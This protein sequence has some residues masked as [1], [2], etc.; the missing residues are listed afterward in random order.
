MTIVTNILILVFLLVEVYFLVR[1]EKRLWNS[2]YTPVTILAV[3]YVLVV[4]LT[5]LLPESLGFV[6]LYYPSLLFWIVGLVLLEVPSILM[7]AFYRKTGGNLDMQVSTPHRQWLLTIVALLLVAVFMVRLRGMVSAQQVMFGSDEFGDEFAKYGLFGHLLVFLIGCMIVFF[8]FIKRKHWLIPVATILSIALL[9]FVNQVKSWVIIPLLAGLLLCMMMGKVRMNMRLLATISIVGIGIF[10]ASY[11]VMFI[12]VNQTDYSSDMG[13]FIGVHVIHYLTSGVLGLS[14]DM[15][16][17]IVET[18]DPEIII[19]PF[20]NI[21]H[22][23]TGEQPIDVVNPN[24]FYINKYTSSVDNVRTFFGELYVFS[25]PYISIMYIFL[26]G[27]FVYSVRIASLCTQSVYII[28][29]DAWFCALLFMGWFD[30]YFYHLRT[31]EVP[32][33]LLMLHFMSKFVFKN[34]K[35]ITWFKQGEKS[36]KAVVKQGE[37]ELC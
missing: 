34:A 6:S 29:I 22:V 2:Y 32:A 1:L 30:F 5:V 26:F 14:E 24:Y 17:G 23:L 3:P 36:E 12:I 35:T 4:L 21:V 11:L 28:S 13:R 25:G 7:S 27:I 19:A 33:Y 20:V 8:S 9:L 15:R 10:A 37:V 18:Q 31:Y 16:L